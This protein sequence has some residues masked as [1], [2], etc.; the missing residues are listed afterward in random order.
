MRPDVKFILGVPHEDPY[1]VAET[2]DI[3]LETDN[4]GRRTI[5]RLAKEMGAKKFLHYPSPAYVHGAFGSAKG[6]HER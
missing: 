2:A 1:L 3:A 6:H 4:L 5:L